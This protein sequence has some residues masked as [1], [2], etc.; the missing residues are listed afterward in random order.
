MV[1]TNR[2]I[3]A[4]NRKKPVDERGKQAAECRQR[5]LR[6]HT[7]G[8]REAARQQTFSCWRV[9]AYPVC[10]ADLARSPDPSATGQNTS[11]GVRGAAMAG[12]KIEIVSEDERHWWRIVAGN[13]EIVAS[14]ETYTTRQAA[15]KTVAAVVEAITEKVRQA[16][17]QAVVVEL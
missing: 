17:H 15:E 11:R 13:G 4:Q 2:G 14:S 16:L 6:H 8:R 3:F 5:R 10:Y 1:W 12:Y 7:P 9:F